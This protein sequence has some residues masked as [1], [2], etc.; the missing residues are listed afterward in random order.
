MFFVYDKPLF[1]TESDPNYLSF[2]VMPM[3]AVVVSSIH[4]VLLSVLNGGLAQCTE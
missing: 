2:F 1:S 3:L 4:C